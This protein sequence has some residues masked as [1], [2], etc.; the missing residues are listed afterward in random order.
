MD[1]QCPRCLRP[2]PA[3]SSFCGRCGFDLRP[4]QV[5][6]KPPPL[7]IPRPR[8]RFVPLLL[9]ASA[10]VAA[11]SLFFARHSHQLEM[12]APPAILELEHDSATEDS[13][14][15]QPEH[16]RGSGAADREAAPSS[17]KPAMEVER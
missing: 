14:K 8:S 9:L 13:S 2:Y 1:A 11:I 4:V 6:V 12:P 10:I 15:T 5:R 17:K 16:E 3:W 7:P